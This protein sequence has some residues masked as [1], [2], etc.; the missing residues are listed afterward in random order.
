MPL[1]RAARSASLS[2]RKARGKPPR[3]ATPARVLPKRNRTARPTR[4]FHWVSPLLRVV[5]RGGN[6]GR[7]LVAA[8]AIRKGT[9]V[10][11]MGGHIM[12]IEQHGRLP[13]PLRHYP[14][15]VSDGLLI[16]RMSLGEPDEPGEFVNHSCDPN[17][18]MQDQLSVV[19]RRNIRAGDP[20]TIDYAMCMTS[21]ILNL[22]CEC[23]EPGCR[24]RITGDDWKRRELQKRYK[25]SFVAYI[26][27]LIAGGRGH[28]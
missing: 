16:G 17:C 19:A 8:K 26:E 20:I 11:M 18:G 15:H 6:I 21:A 22:A 5:D 25:G 23:R 14:T 9:L 28:N 13:E 1:T 7:S 24:G 10:L 12:T 27:R 2:T 3:T 4:P